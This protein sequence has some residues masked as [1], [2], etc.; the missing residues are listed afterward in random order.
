[1]K[2]TGGFQPEGALI[3]IQISQSMSFKGPQ[4]RDLDAPVPPPKMTY[5]N[6]VK[7]KLIRFIHAPSTMQGLHYACPSKRIN[8]NVT[9][10][11]APRND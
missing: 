4:K 2:V 7:M 6:S 1:M 3:G 5:Q 11:F 10:S 9:L 8:F